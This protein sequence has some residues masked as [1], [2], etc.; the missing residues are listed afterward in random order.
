MMTNVVSENCRVGLWRQST[1]LYS[2]LQYMVQ[3]NIGVNC[4]AHGRPIGGSKLKTV[5]QY[6]LQIGPTLE[7]RVALPERSARLARDL[8]FAGTGGRAFAEC[9]EFSVRARTRTE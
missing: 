6:V 7:L 8:H 2:I 9:N 3:Y 1:N 5:A 4:I